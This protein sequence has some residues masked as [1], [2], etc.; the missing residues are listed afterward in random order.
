MKNKLIKEFKELFVTDPL[1]ISS[2]GRI[3]LIGEHTDY[4]NGL[5]LPAAINKQM[6]FAFSNATTNSTIISSDLQETVTCTFLENNSKKSWFTYFYG[7]IQELQKR[8]LNT[9]PFNC[10]F[11]SDIPIGA[12]LSSSAALTCGFLFGLNNLNNFN[13]KDID[14]CTIAQSVEHNY[15]GVKCGIMDQF[16][17]MM[18]KKNNFLKLDCETMEH[19]QVS[20]N[21][22]KYSFILCDTQVS[23]NLAQTE[24]N[25]RREQCEEGIAL[26]KVHD[27]S[28]NSLRDVSIEFLEQFRS[29]LSEIVFRRCLFVISENARVNDVF[30]YLAKGQLEKVG[31]KLNQSHFGLKHN[32]NVSCNELDFLVDIASTSSGVLGARM[33]G[34]GFGGCTLNLIKNNSINSFIANS[35]YYYLQKFNTELKSYT[36]QI[37]DGTRIIK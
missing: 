23:H 27:E 33:M 29:E 30:D 34:G 8:G 5:V 13:L 10:I 36:I 19:M 26:L 18:G 3:N 31:R 16:A 1:L 28:I 25:L 17:N 22:D 21:L 32:Y 15:V 12:G 35:E 4:N 37:G 6:I 11:V 7:V 14:I 9:K 24:Y 2:P 20:S